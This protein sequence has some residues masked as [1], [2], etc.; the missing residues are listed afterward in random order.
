MTSQQLTYVVTQ[1]RIQE[2]RRQAVRPGV[3]E[4]TADRPQRRLTRVL[5]VR[6]RPARRAATPSSTPR[7][8]GVC[9]PVSA[10]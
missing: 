10:N 6:I 5:R 4:L 9:E 1:T 3:R 7:V 2:L 8:D